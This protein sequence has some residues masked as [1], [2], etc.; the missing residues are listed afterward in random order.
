MTEELSSSPLPQADGPEFV[1]RTCI[2]Q[3]TVIIQFQM[4]V[5]SMDEAVFEVSLKNMTIF[6]GG[7]IFQFLTCIMYHVILE[8]IL[9]HGSN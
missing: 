5:A 3:L 1:F 8:M 4:G 9:N 2:E 7:G 6:F